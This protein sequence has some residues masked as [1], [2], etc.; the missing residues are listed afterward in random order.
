MGLS[1]SDAGVYL[2][3]GQCPTRILKVV[4]EREP[5]YL[6]AIIDGISHDRRAGIGVFSRV[7]QGSDYIAQLED[8]P[9][10][11]GGRGVREREVP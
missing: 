7:G 10:C 3:L 8:G 6:L 2:I 4:P 11:V 5:R 9:L 1:I